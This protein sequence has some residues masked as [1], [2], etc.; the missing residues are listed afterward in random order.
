MMRNFTQNHVS[1]AAAQGPYA[2]SVCL[3][4]IVLPGPM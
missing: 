2:P 4:G 3:K 1:G